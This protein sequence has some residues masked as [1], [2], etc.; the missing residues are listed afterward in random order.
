[1]QNNLDDAHTQ[2]SES[3]ITTAMHDGEML[4]LVAIEMH[5]GDPHEMPQNIIQRECGLPGLTFKQSFIW[6][7]AI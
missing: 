7:S 3:A 1:M 6:R 5:L 4:N 2:S